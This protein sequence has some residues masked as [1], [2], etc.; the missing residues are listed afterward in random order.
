VSAGGTAGEGNA[1]S[2]GSASA[3]ATKIYS[4]ESAL[5]GFTIN[6][7]CPGPVANT[8]CVPVPAPPLPENALVALGLDGAV[9]DVDPGSASLTFKFTTGYQSANFAANFGSGMEAGLNVAGKVIR[10]QVRAGAGSPMTAFAKMYVKTGP[11]Y[12]YANSTQVELRPEVWT[13][14]AFDTGVP[15]SYPAVVDPNQFT[16]DDVRELGMEIGA[17]MASAGTAVIHVDTIFY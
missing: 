5:E 15:P 10:A 9:G 17:S 11:Q 7:Y 13:S 4:F 6:Y 14:V 12:Y 1:G 16:L 3:M 8:G 2:G